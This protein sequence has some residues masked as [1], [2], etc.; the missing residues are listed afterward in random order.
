ML[1]SNTARQD[2]ARGRYRS[3]PMSAKALVDDAGFLLAWMQAPLRT[4]AVASSSRGLARAMADAVDPGNPGPIVELGPGTGPMTRALLDRGFDED[5]LVL[6][7]FNP[8]FYAALKARHPHAT[9]LQGDAYAIADL[10]TGLDI[11]P[12][13]GVVSSLPLLTKP[14]E[15]R[16]KLAMDALRLCGP[17]GSFVQFT[18][19]PKSPVPVD[20]QQI[21]A[22][23]TRKIWRNLPPASVWRYTMKR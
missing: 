23:M 16:R 8:D 22:E 6:I 10:V 2:P 12:V 17:S 5:R 13:S 14:T 18:Y 4:G 9:V 11:G 3:G 15:V 7:E 1:R 19:G 20:R 21:C